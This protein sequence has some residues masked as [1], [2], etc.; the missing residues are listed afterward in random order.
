MVTSWSA[1]SRTVIWIAIGDKNG[2]YFEFI[3]SNLLI[4]FIFKEHLNFWLIDRLIDWVIHSF[5]RSFMCGVSCKFICVLITWL[6]VLLCV[7][8]WIF[9]YGSIL[10]DLNVLLLLFAQSSR[11]TAGPRKEHTSSNKFLFLKR[12]LWKLTNSVMAQ[13]IQSSSL[14]RSNCIF[15]CWFCRCC[16]CWIKRYKFSLELRD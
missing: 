2:I 8:R 12:T 3:N 9:V 13:M 4:C 15:W 1:V 11:T 7:D 14:R 16:C 5:I 6:Y 10:A